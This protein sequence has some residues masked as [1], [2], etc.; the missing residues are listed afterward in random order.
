[1]KCISLGAG[2]LALSSL[3]ACDGGE[4]AACTEH[5]VTFA[6]VV[7]NHEGAPMADVD[8]TA[9]N[10]DSGRVVTARTGPDGTTSGIGESVGGGAVRIMA[11]YD[12]MSAAID[13]LW[14]CDACHCTPSQGGATLILNRAVPCT[15]DIQKVAL[16]VANSA[17]QPVEGV[18][19][20]ATNL[21]SD[22][23][24]SSP[25]TVD[26]QTYIDEQI[27][28]GTVRFVAE[29]NGRTSPPVEVQM[30]RVTCHCQPD[31]QPIA[32]TLPD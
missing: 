6:L 14:A 31:Y 25:P 15:M 22:R 17:S 20:T 9:T 1:M 11:T 12:G 18:V 19:V 30:N 26:G 8:V 13:T 29:H 16:T 32:L 4:D 10:L 24:Q 27:G 2:L 21:D 5:Y 23:T 28:C 7:T 3:V